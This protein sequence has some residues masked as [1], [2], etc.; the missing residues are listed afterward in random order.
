[1]K[2]QISSPVYIVLAVFLTV[3]IPSIKAQ[4]TETASGFS[5]S[6]IKYSI[7]AGGSI[8]F[9][10][11]DNGIH[12]DPMHIL[13]SPGLGLKAEF[14]DVFSVEAA[15][16]MYFA[17]YGYSDV[18]GRAV[19]MSWENRTAFV[20]GNLLSIQAVRRFTFT[21]TLGLRVF[22][23]LGFDLRLVLRAPDLHP[24]DPLDE[25][26]RQ[27]KLVSEYFW[28]NGR[29]FLPV[30]GTGLDINLNEKMRLGVDLRAWM[31]LYALL[32]DENLSDFEGWRFGIGFRVMFLNPDK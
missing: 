2:A 5:F 16:D 11:Q 7:F 31:P 17:T 13:P 8:I 29:W 15:L 9:F 22:G 4:D 24:L 26:D 23:G 10:P 6:N 21:E 20:W 25:I 27:T 19:P 1:M 28:G 14:S 12:A 3:C 30:I 18:L 32:G